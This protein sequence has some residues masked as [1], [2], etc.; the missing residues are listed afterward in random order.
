MAKDFFLRD[1][2][3]NYFSGRIRDSKRIF[4][5]ADCWYEEFFHVT[6]SPSSGQV[7]RY[8]LEHQSVINAPDVWEFRFYFSSTMQK[9]L[10]D[11]LSADIWYNYTSESLVT[12]FRK[13][14]YLC[15]YVIGTKVDKFEDVYSINVH[16]DFDHLF[17]IVSGKMSDY[18]EQ[19]IATHLFEICLRIKE[20]LENFDINRAYLVKRPETHVAPTRKS[21]GRNQMPEWARDLINGSVRI[22]IKMAGSFIGANIDSNFD[23]GN[24]DFGNFDSGDVGDIGDFDTNVDGDFDYDSDNDYNHISFGHAP[25]DGTYTNSGQSVTIQ[26]AGGNNKGSYDVYYH[27]G[28]KYIDFQNQW[29]KIQGKTRFHLNGN[30]YIIKS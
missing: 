21:S 4:P 8:Y 14:P 27:H 11:F 5:D 3:E 6:Y 1:P 29:V 9:Q 26:V 17:C 12:A 25:N 2:N 7:C 19:R 15:D 10:C 23:I 22:G 16:P 18:R 20:E 13:C 28:D 24:V 30:D